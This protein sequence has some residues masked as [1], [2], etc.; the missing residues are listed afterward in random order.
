MSPSPRSLTDT[1]T[2][3]PG[4]SVWTAANR[5]WKARRKYRLLNFMLLTQ[6]RGMVPEVHRALLKFVWAQRRLDGQH[7][8]YETAL[9][10]RILP[11]SRYVRKDI[12]EVV[13][14]DLILGLVLLEGAF[15]K[16]HLKPGVKHFVHYPR[17]TG[18]HSLLRIL[19]MMAF[20]RW[21]LLYYLCI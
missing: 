11:G 15:P 4:R 7:P 12:L 1:N 18:T 17:Y 8:S 9:S 14:R 20:E 10:L 21:M 19:W 13:N 16:S 5:M 3:T 6:L 2:P